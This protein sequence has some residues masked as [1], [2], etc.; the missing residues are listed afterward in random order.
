MDVASLYVFPVF[1]V[2][3]IIQI[4]TLKKELSVLKS[5]KQTF[6]TSSSTERIELFLYSETDKKAQELEKKL[7]AQIASNDRYIKRL[8]NRLQK[9]QEISKNGKR[10][11]SQI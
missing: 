10:C 8:K 9:S 5:D 2:F 1:I 7:M 6:A 11:A 4:L 3:E